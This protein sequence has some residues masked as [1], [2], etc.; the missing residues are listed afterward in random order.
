MKDFLKNVL[1]TIV[2]LI[3]FLLVIG[4]LGAMS[5]VGMVA[6]SD[7]TTK[8]KENSV[9][10]LDLDGMLNER[11]EDDIWGQL[12]GKVS[13][14]IGLEDV[15][16][17]IRD[18]K[19]I[20][21][22]K[23]IYIESGMFAA[24]SH[25]SM[26]AVRKALVDFKKSG[27]WV[28]A[29]G[30]QYTQ[31]T[32]YIASAADKVWMNPIG[33]V[34]WMGLGTEP[35]Y[36]KDLM[37]K[38]G[39]KMQLA[40]VG[41]YKSAP[42]MFTADKMSDPNR[43]QVT[44]YLGGVWNTMLE[45][46]SA[47]RKISKDSLNA[48]ADRMVAFEDPQNLV[49]YKMVDKLMY[50]DEVKTEIKKIL[51]LEDDDDLNQ[52]SIAQMQNVKKESEKG[53]EIAVYYA[54]GDIVDEIASGLAGS[55]RHSIVGTE[56]SKDLERLMDDDGVK[57]V[58]LRVN[59]PGGSAYAS[60]QIWRAVKRLK[61]KKPVVVSMGGYAASGGYYIS[62]GAN[63][64][65]AEPTTL[66]GSIGIFGMFPDFSG[67]LTQKLGVKFDEVKTN[68]HATFGTMSRP[69]NEEE[70][71]Y[72]N[73]YIDR[74]YKLFR[75]RVA[76]GRRQTPDAIEK[77]AQGHVW[78]GKDALK[79]KLVDQLGGLDEAVKK[80]AE[81]AKIDEYYTSSYPGKVSWKDQLFNNLSDAK[82]NYLD[83]EL[84]ATLGDYYEPFML[85]KNINKE[86]AIQARLPFYMNIKY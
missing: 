67:L 72:L 56:M 66:T 13:N 52:I 43:E 6:A 78:L 41:A 45:D 34:N 59:S 2:G 20:D 75:K 79:I 57:A 61:T 25:A 54:Y 76:D 65:V 85:I 71:S 17:A 60:E 74:G 9:L 23:G 19:K 14:S 51:K 21:N 4:A 77:V 29:Y 33:M 83:A 3:V 11:S 24:D 1:A 30:D 50:N 26:Q 12:T 82:G 39:V 37:A 81:L 64:I 15:L 73:M 32:Y 44:A 68:R 63:W 8:V 47:S 86:N 55:N 31:G 38:F 42:E 36:I 53:E 49:K 27:K 80:A 58:V 48:Y 10:V 69:F 46:I 40:K 62:C 22:I 16:S 84:R 5:I 35:Y 28:I 70:M 7:S 18:A